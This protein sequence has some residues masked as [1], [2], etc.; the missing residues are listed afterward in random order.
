MNT[1][2][3][4]AW[5]TCRSN[6][7]PLKTNVFINIWFLILVGCRLYD[8]RVS[9]FESGIDSLATNKSDQFRVCSVDCTEVKFPWQFLA[10][11][12]GETISWVGFRGGAR[13]CWMFASHSRLGSVPWQIDDFWGNLTPPSSS[14]SSAAIED[15]LLGRR[16][17]IPSDP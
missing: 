14:D 7:N 15:F 12:F 5:S 11:L 9:T 16:H 3:C 8:W 13:S 10:Q 2:I 6:Q 17:T 4:W 1:L